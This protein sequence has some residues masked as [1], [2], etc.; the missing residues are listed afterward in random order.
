MACG[1]ED[2]FF[3][4]VIHS[5]LVYIS[6]TQVTPPLALQQAEFGDLPAVTPED[7]QAMFAG[8]QKLQLIDTRP[9]H[10]TTRSNEIVAGAVWRDPER[11]AEWITTL[12]KSEP[13]VTFCVYGFHVG[14]QTATAL[15]EAGFDAR[16]MRG[17]HAAWKALDGPMVMFKPAAQLV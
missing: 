10:Y 14:C 15:R 5:L 11:I 6:A 2:A 8:G 12:S 4:G 9:R 13:V 17:G 7:V 1:K 3:I 16:Y